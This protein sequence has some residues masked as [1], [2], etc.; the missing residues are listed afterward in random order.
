MRED[1][2]GV[3]IIV[4]KAEV[5]DGVEYFQPKCREK[6]IFFEKRNRWPKLRD[7]ERCSLF[8]I[9]QLKTEFF[10]QLFWTCNH[11]TYEL[12]FLSAKD[13]PA[14]QCHKRTHGSLLVN[15]MSLIFSVFFHNTS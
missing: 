14:S 12:H 9:P 13:Q 7:R 6:W 10:Y 8:K 15:E 11:C 4:P 1:F 5:D 3:M 2:R